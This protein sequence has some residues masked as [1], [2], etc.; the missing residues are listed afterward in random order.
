MCELGVTMCLPRPMVV[1]PPYKRIHFGDDLS[2]M[3]ITV[4]TPLVIKQIGSQHNELIQIKSDKLIES[5]TIIIQ[6]V[7]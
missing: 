4:E 6:I 1:K 7:T 5:Y 3:C 2:H